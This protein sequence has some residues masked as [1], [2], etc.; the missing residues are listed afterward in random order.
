MF[1]YVIIKNNSFNIYN[2][3]FVLARLTAIILS[4]FMFWFGLKSTSVEKI[5]FQEGNFNTPLF[6]LTCLGSILVL[7]AWIM[8][9]FIMFHCKKRR[10][11][12]KPVVSTNK[13]SKPVKRR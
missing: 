3:L 9:N 1:N 11:N 2:V 8:W 7:Q 10:E 5:N 13:T 4:I 12:S 6:R